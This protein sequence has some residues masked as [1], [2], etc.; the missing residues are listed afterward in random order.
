MSQKYLFLAGLTMVA[1]LVATSIPGYA[2]SQ[3]QD[4]K[5][6]TAFIYVGPKDYGWSYMHEVARR[7]IDEKFPWL[8][9]V[10]AEDVSEANIE[11]Y[12]KRFV[13]EEECDII[14]TTSFAFMDAT[15]EAAKKYPDTIFFNC[16]GYKRA[17]NVA[18][19]FAEFYQLYYLNGL[20][21]GALTKTG[22]L[23]YVAAYPTPEVV[24]HI[25]AFALGVK[26]TNPGATV[27][28]RWLFAWY[29]PTKARTAAESLIKEGCDVLAF[30]ED[31]PAVVKV[32]QEYTE[33]GEP[34][35]T[36]AN[37]SPMQKLG[38]D[39]CVSGQLV[40]WEV[41]YQDILAKVYAEVYTSRNLAD[42]D[43]WWML[44]DK[45]VELG[46]EFDAPINPK[47][48]SIFR[49]QKIIDPLLGEISIYD[50]VMRR[51]GE[52]SE[53][54]VLFDPFTGPIK[55][56]E[57]KVRI[58]T[59]RRA[60]HDELWL[61]D[62]FVENIVGKFP[63]SSNDLVCEKRIAATAV[64]SAAVGLGGI[65]K[66]ISNEKDRI[67][68]IRAFITPIRFYP[69]KSG[70]FYVYDTDCVNIAHAVQKNLQGKNLYDYQD[71]KGKFVIREL[72]AKAK[73]GGGFVEYYWVHP[74]SEG[75]DRK[76]GYVELI[77]G[78]GYFI[79]SG[80]YLN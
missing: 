44:Q 40:H 59:G 54:T 24:R 16:S 63:H 9:T 51:L 68:L 77:P 80:V 15:I 8:E 65:M 53:V 46:G 62:W 79:G 33:K 78:T 73:E 1:I 34:V 20:M 32:G 23:G 31:S 47:F 22:K 49:Q 21:A 76:I 29:D 28:V 69:D 67:E 50:L 26:K 64:H 18:T 42:V 48:K 56:Q 27:D 72:A 58:G 13:I 70:Y 57:G 71:I 39:S 14:F 10:Y 35:Y 66:N 17:S 41:L 37:Y 45:A 43:Y 61:M 19:Y 52:M 12:I 30:T 3:M 55:D 5:I 7:Y 2:T 38:P 74:D 36:F 11:D 4:E 25:N 6:K 60:S 75:E